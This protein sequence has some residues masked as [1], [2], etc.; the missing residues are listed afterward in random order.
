MSPTIRDDAMSIVG[1]EALVDE[2]E[3]RSDEYK[4]KKRKQMEMMGEAT[5]AAAGAVVIKSDDEGNETVVER[6]MDAPAMPAMPYGGAKTLKD[7][8]LYMKQQDKMYEIMDSFH[9]LQNVMENVVMDSELKDKPAAIKSLIG[10]FKGRVDD[11]VKR[12][13]AIRAAQQILSIEKDGDTMADEQK[14]PVVANINA[15]TPAPAPVPTPLE[16]A[17]A[18]L[19]KAVTLASGSNVPLDERYKSVQPALNSFADVIKST[20]GG[21]TGKSVEL[22]TAI[23]KAVAEQLQPVI[24]EMRSAVAAPIMAPTVP[25]PR[26]FQPR[27]VDESVGS[28][29]K[30]PLTSMI[31]RSVGLRE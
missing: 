26:A 3:S 28:A 31:R 20:V 15:T 30:S 13:L 21:D 19:N 6:M 4:R 14:T 27:S 5:E 16:T 10:E 17:F 7:A 18:E 22:A 2:L 24:A 12:S 23:S 29:P 8:E 9:M 11:A 1:D 25:G